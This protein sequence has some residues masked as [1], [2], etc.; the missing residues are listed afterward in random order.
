MRKLLLAMLVLGTVACTKEVEVE[1]IVYREDTSITNGLRAE[2][3]AAIA[4]TQATAN[5]LAQAQSTIESLNV[6]LNT[7]NSE[8]ATIDDLT[9]QLDALNTEIAILQA[10]LA[11]ALDNSE[12]E[13]TIQSLVD[14]IAELEAM[15]VEVIIEYIT[16]VETVVVDNPAHLATISQLQSQIANLTSQL[17]NAQ[18]NAPIVWVDSGYTIAQFGVGTNDDT[19]YTYLAEGATMYLPDTIRVNDIVFNIN[20]GITATQNANGLRHWTIK[21]NQN[22]GGMTDSAKIYVPEGHQYDSTKRWYGNSHGVAIEGPNGENLL[23]WYWFYSTDGQF[24]SSTKDVFTPVAEG[25][26]IY[27]AATAEQGIIYREVTVGVN[28]DSRYTG[29]I[30]R[31]HYFTVVVSEAVSF[32]PGI[33]TN[34]EFSIITSTAPTTSWESVFDSFE[35]SG[36]ATANGESIINENVSSQAASIVANGANAVNVEAGETIRFKWLTWGTE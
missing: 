10:D 17:A 11:V 33:A 27:T 5:Q 3:A 18:S 28:E 31:Y 29:T 35:S 19:F 4:D 24:V 36:G 13:A 20:G 21:N 22:T 34:L 15:E 30:R 7:L 14:Q 32:E 8:L 23:D 12:D 9:E 26:W 1:K 16:V 6:E 2:L 25:E